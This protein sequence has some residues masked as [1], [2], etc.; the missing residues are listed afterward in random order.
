MPSCFGNV[1]MGCRCLTWLGGGGKIGNAE[2]AEGAARAPG[3]EGEAGGAGY[4]VGIF[5]IYPPIPA[6]PNIPLQAE[7]RQDRA[8]YKLTR[9][10]SELGENNKGR[11]QWVK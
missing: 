8:P 2:G 1:Q 6:I 4:D 9:S 5:G 11:L 3:G 7:I 10:G